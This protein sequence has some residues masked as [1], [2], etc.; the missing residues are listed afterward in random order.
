MKLKKLSVG[1]MT[2]VLTAGLLASPAMASEVTDAAAVQNGTVTVQAA[3]TENGTAGTGTSDDIQGEIKDTGKDD[4]VER[5]RGKR[6]YRQ[7]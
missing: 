4:A 3:A 2:A 6:R 1:L 5:N 7:G